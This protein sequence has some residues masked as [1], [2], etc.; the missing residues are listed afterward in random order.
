MQA[1]SADRG[2][3]SYLGRGHSRLAP[4]TK[5]VSVRCHSVVLLNVVGIVIPRHGLS[6]HGSH[7]GVPT[8]IRCQKFDLGLELFTSIVVGGGAGPRALRSGETV[9]VP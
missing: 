8:P 6:R 9:P 1:S 4:L 5:V 3:L 2:A 7:R